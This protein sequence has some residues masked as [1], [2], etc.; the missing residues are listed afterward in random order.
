MEN[1]PIE[2]SKLGWLRVLEHVMVVV[3]T[4]EPPANSADSTLQVPSTVK[5]ST[6]KTQNR[7][8]LAKHLTSS[9]V[10]GYAA[11]IAPV[12]STTADVPGLKWAPSGRRLVPQGRCDGAADDEAEAEDEMEDEMEDVS[13][14]TDED[15]DD[16]DDEDNE[17]TEEGADEDTDE[18][19]DEDA[20]EDGVEDDTD[21][22]D[23]LQR[24]AV[25]APAP[26][27]LLK[28]TIKENRMV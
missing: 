1:P 19:T 2:K 26:R 23:G 18:D 21:T 4:P 6:P 14:E 9:G 22:R 15:N 12:V 8:L 17:D 3:V 28:P 20:D 25:A 7:E 27:R 13:D 10:G 24:A 16:N 11:V 5:M